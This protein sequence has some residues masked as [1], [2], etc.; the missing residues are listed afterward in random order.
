MIE[1][2]TGWRAGE[3][4]H[5][6]F[7]PERID[8][9][10][11]TWNFGNTPKIVSGFS[12]S[13]LVWVDKFYRSITESVVVAKTL[14][15]AELAKVFENTYRQVNIALVNEL[16]RHAHSLGVDVRNV[17]DLAETKPFGFTK[18]TPGPGV[19]GHCL[20][21]DPVYLTHHL[22]TEFGQAFRIVELAQEINDSQP[23][24]VVRRLQDA[25]N[26]QQTALKGASVLALGQSYKPGT[27]DMRESPAVQVVELLRAKGAR[28]TVVDPHF[29]ETDLDTLREIPLDPE[30]GM[31][32]GDFDAVVLLTPHKEFDLQRV[33]DQANYVLDTWGVMPDAPHI[34]RL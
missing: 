27:A 7:S 32:C 3:D 26:V 33:A 18:F 9:G 14:E 2:N 8:P 31:N 17:L 1:R 20:P 30:G 4:F 23:A 21:V 6:G 24:Y 28:V 25:L 12:T 19:G 29:E 16:Q 11:E 5:V 10:N 22:R 15:E 34:E 13:C